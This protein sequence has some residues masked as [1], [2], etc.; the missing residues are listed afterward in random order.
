MNRRFTLIE[1]LV[2]I[3]IIA[4][5]ASMLL[6]ALA[7]ARA[8]AKSNSCVNSLKSIGLASLMYANDYNDWL[9]SPNMNGGGTNAAYN[10]LVNNITN[11]TAMSGRVF[12]IYNGY[13]TKG[14]AASSEELTTMRRRHYRCPADAVV[15]SA[16][17]DSYYMLYYGKAW[18]PYS[19]RFGST[20]YARAQLSDGK[21]GN[22]I[23]C[24]AGIYSVDA[25][26][27]YII[28]GGETNALCMAGNVVTRKTREALL[29]ASILNALRQ[30]VGYGNLDAW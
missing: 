17:Q 15:F 1:L 8:K 26:N 18:V 6:P 21:P 14:A 13:L 4:I 19:Y 20:D 28:H 3:A 5:L 9:V 10:S 11:A 27:N 16:S 25:T 24:D 22:I 12:L 2:V 23:A 30:G 29:C 7:K